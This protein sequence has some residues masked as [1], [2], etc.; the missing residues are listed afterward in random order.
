M[1]DRRLD[2]RRN[3]EKRVP[4]DFS[5]WQK[6]IHWLMAL[7]IMAMLIAGQNF[8]DPAK[9]LADRLWSRSQHGSGGIVLGV[10]L[11]IR[12]LLRWRQG[13]PAAATTGPRW[14]R[15]LSKLSH[16]GLYAVMAALVGSGIAVAMYTTHSMP[17]PVLGGFDI[18][19][20][21]NS[22]EELYRELR[23]YHALVTDIAIGFVALHV[24]AAFYHLFWVRDRLA[25]RM[26]RFWRR[27]DVAGP[28]RTR[29]GRT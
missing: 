24:A 17:L 2:L 7:L 18:S 21:G 9:E 13:V 16:L 8:N 6:S 28:A 27:E 20:A 4:G 12:I 15:V 23:G 14:Q 22:S 26:A 29:G 11:V 10:L 5:V 3:A 25:Q 1:S 19:L